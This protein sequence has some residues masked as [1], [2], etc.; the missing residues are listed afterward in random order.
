MSLNLLFNR[1]DS[2][3]I[4]QRS[5]E[6]IFDYSPEFEADSV[7]EASSSC[8]KHRDFDHTFYTG[9]DY[10]KYR[11]PCDAQVI[12]LCELSSDVADS[13]P[14]DFPLRPPSYCE[15]SYVRFE[16]RT[17]I[18]YCEDVEPTELSTCLLISRSDSQ[19]ERESLTN[20]LH[21]C[22]H[23]YQQRRAIQMCPRIRA[24]SSI[25]LFL[26]LL[27]FIICFLFT[28]LQSFYSLTIPFSS[29]LHS[30]HNFETIPIRS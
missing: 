20:L 27:S 19:S 15:D 23:H 1:S 6:S 8:S 14:E 7:T 3:N 11:L 12:E 4:T 21:S 29:E 5:L 16:D 30:A 25:N 10:H 2:G 24:E 9:T 22:D 17:S 18:F 13:E 28:I 26:H